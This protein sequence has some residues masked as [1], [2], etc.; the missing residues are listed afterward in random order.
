[1]IRFGDNLNRLALMLDIKLG[2]TRQPNPRQPAFSF[3]L[4]SL[5][6]DRRL[7]GDPYDSQRQACECVPGGMAILLHRFILGLF[8]ATN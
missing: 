1:M 6:H 7:R 5:A 2:S 3:V 8:A 4:G